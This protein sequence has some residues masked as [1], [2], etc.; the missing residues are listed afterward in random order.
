MKLLK[1]AG[2]IVC[3]CALFH[4]ANSVVQM[5]FLIMPI[6]LIAI[7]VA[8]VKDI[9]KCFDNATEEKNEWI[10]G[11]VFHIYAAVVLTEASF[12]LHLYFYLPAILLS[13]ITIAVLLIKARSKLAETF[14]RKSTVLLTTGCLV[15]IGGTLIL[16]IMYIGSL[17]I[18]DLS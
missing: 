12:L 14:E 2:G 13:Y 15:A 1:A 6:L 4:L 11:A 10:I 18:S 7:S 9:G 16:L 5:I 3:I 8:A 17:I